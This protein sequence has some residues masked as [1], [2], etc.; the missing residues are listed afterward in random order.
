MDWPALTMLV[1]LFGGFAIVAWRF[2]VDSRDPNDR[3]PFLPER[4]PMMRSG[5][6]DRP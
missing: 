6:V 2:G 4:E 1:G 3:D 5:T